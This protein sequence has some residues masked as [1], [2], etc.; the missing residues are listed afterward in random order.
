MG[1]TRKSMVNKGSETKQTPTGPS[2]GEVPSCLL[3][4]VCGKS[5]LLLGPTSKDQTKQLMIR[6]VENAETEES[7]R[8]RKG[9]KA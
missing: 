4:L 2:W 6:E 3:F 9:I 5:F 1:V 7:S 8:A